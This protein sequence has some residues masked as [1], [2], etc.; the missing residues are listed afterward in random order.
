MLAPGLSLAAGASSLPA[1][2]PGAALSSFAGG[3]W[4]P[5]R[6]RQQRGSEQRAA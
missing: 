5:R 2:P 3:S 6:F 4:R 1:L